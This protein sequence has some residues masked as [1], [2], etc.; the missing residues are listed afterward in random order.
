MRAHRWSDNDKYFGPFT[1]ANSRDGWRPLSFILSSGDGDEYPGARVRI[2]GFGHTLIV[3]LPQWVLRPHREKVVA[4]YWSEETIKRHG[5]NWYWQAWS[6]EYGFCV[7]EGH[8]SVS[9][10]RQTHD[11]TTDKTWGCFIPWKQW[12]HVRASLYDTS[13]KHYWTDI[14][15]ARVGTIAWEQ[16]REAEKRCPKMRF[17][18]EDYDGE[19]ITATTHIEERE[20]HFGEG[21]FKWLSWFRK[22]KICRSLDIRFSAE[23]GRRKG[24][25][26]GGTVGHAIDM[27]PGE[28]HEAAFRRYCVEHDMTF[29]GPVISEAFE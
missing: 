13:G 24:S 1:Y 3:A 20:W 26:K 19:I 6:R 25:W 18:F 2:S 14:P 23:T 5:Q 11:S 17:G 10:G 4:Q 22:P 29:I 9:H 12:R 7:S 16:N 28:L 27:L 15:D 8:L 21:W